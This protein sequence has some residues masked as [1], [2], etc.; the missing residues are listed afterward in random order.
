M[1]AAIAPNM[2][3][4]S[5]VTAAHIASD[6]T[7]RAT[8]VAIRL[9][10]ACSAATRSSAC[11]ASAFATAVAT[12]S[13]NWPRRATDRSGIGSGSVE[14]AMITPHNRPS[15]LIGVPM[16]DRNPALRAVRAIS[17]SRLL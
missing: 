13:V 1:I 9:S 2:S 6:S 15:T 8:R 14:I 7:P 4:I 12:S 3:A 17:P 16:A 11:R 10:A 5:W